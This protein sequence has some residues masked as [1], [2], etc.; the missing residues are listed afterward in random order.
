MSRMLPLR[1]LRRCLSCGGVGRCSSLL[2]SGS[3]S[4][5][6]VV[7]PCFFFF[8]RFVGGG[9]LAVDVANGSSGSE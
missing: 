6:V 4:N 3:E 1:I 8:F 2:V 5:S 7:A 9:V